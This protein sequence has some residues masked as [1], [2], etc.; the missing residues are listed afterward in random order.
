MHSC[1]EDSGRAALLMVSD[2]LHGYLVV[3]C[4]LLSGWFVPPVHYDAAV[5][6]PLHHDG[7]GQI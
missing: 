2:V 5:C 6:L 4:E 1:R 7:L 3:L